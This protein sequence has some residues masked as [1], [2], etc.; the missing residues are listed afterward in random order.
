MAQK[1]ERRRCRPPKRSV[2]APDRLQPQYHRVASRWSTSTPR[3]GVHGRPGLS[4]LHQHWL[5]EIRHVDRATGFGHLVLAFPTQF[6]R[7]MLRPEHSPAGW[8][9]PSCSGMKRSRS[10]W[11]RRAGRWAGVDQ[12]CGLC[13]HR[14]SRRNRP[15]QQSSRS[16]QRRKRGAGCSVER[17]SA[18]RDP[19]SPQPP[20]VI[21]AIVRGDIAS[22]DPQSQRRRPRTPGSFIPFMDQGFFSASSFFFWKYP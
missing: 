7:S 15:Q 22:S 13:C 18:I 12:L 16:C 17:V 19:F 20:F 21:E 4:V 6:E 11:R 9:S 10:K 5:E 3:L 1:T 14:E 2:T 8:A